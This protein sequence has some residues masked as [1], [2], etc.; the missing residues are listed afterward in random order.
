[1]G[2][3]FL[4]LILGDHCRIC[5]WARLYTYN[6]VNQLRWIL[7]Q[8]YYILVRGKDRNFADQFGHPP[9]GMSKRLDQLISRAKAKVLWH[10]HG[11]FQISAAV[12]QDLQFLF[13]YLSNRSNPWSMSIGHYIKRAPIG[14]SYGD[15]STG[16]GMGFYSHTHKFY[17]VMVWSDE[18]RRRIHL[19]NHKVAVH[20]NQL[21]MVAYLMQ[22]A[23]VV[24]AIQNPSQLPDD[25][26]ASL[27]NCP[28][29]PQWLVYVDNMTAKFWGEKGIATTLRGQLL[30]RIQ[31][32]LYYTSDVH[33]HEYIT[34]EDNGL[35]DLLS[36]SP[37]P[38]LTIDAFSSFIE[39]V[40][41]L[42]VELKT[43]RFFLPSPSFLCLLCSVLLNNASLTIEC[44]PK[45]LGQFVHTAPAT[46]SGVTL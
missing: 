2:Y 44:L 15:A 6:I 10:D 18:L 14:C 25:V 5:R 21:E 30:L 9:R 46:Y 33:G 45:E 37:E 42:H 23:A 28:T 43:Y 36:R 41:T 11:R 19:K 29:A 34:S 1:M 4:L 27:R 22:L 40:L 38:P 16:R 12:R 35:A 26:A 8:R 13:T 20:I 3:L 31:A 24:T 17:C 7:N 39:Q 32:A